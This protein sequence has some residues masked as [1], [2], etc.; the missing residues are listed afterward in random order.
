MQERSTPEKDT[1]RFR[2]S[3]LWCRLSTGSLKRVLQWGAVMAPAFSNPL[4]EQRTEQWTHAFSRE[5]CIAITGGLTA[6]ETVTL[7]AKTDEYAANPATPEKQISNAFTTL[8]M[9]HCHEMDPF[10]KR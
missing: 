10:S 3:A 2:F 7:R 8:I 6:S 4:D 1:L 5:G 9:H